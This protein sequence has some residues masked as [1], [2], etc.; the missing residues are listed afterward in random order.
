MSGYLVSVFKICSLGERPN[1]VFWRTNYIS[2][3]V[4]LISSYKSYGHDFKVGN[5][6]VITIFGK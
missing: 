3:A 6:T 5:V 1:T 4:G 2:M